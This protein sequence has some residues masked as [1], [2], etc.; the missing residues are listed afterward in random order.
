MSK[1]EQSAREAIAALPDLA[2]WAASLSPSTMIPTGSSPDGPGFWPERSPGGDDC[3]TAWKN[4]VELSLKQRT[5]AVADFKLRASASAGY[6][7]CYWPEVNLSHGA[8]EVETRGFFDLDT[9]P[10]SDFWAAWIPSQ[11][12]ER[13]DYAGGGLLLAWIPTNW[14]ERVDLGVCVNPE[15]CIAWLCHKT[16]PK[17]CRALEEYGYTVPTAMELAKSGLNPWQD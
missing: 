11:F 6:F 10:L 16:A 8:A 12:D 1:L 14:L 5:L 9:V 2:A 13:P 7:L 17:L 3:D 4:A 15:Q